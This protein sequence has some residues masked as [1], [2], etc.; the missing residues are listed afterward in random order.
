MEKLIIAVSSRA[1]FHIEDGNDIFVQQGQEA[2]DAY[3]RSK[4][5]TPLRPGAAFNLV[6]KLLKL[7]EVLV[8]MGRPALVDVVIL[9]RNS[10]DAG[11]RVMNSIAHYGLPIERAV[12]TQG[13][14]RFRYAKAFGAQLF[15]S[16]NPSDVRTAIENGM[17]A[18]TLVPYESDHGDDTEVRIAFDGD[19]VIFG[20]ESDAQYRA[21]G[22]AGWRDFE[23]ENAH[24][25]LSDGPFKRVLELMH[26]IQSAFEGGPCPVKI[27]LV[28]ARGMPAHKRVIR[29]LRHWGLRVDKAIFAGGRP[30]GPLL[31]AFGADMFFDDT[32]T[33]V[34]SAAECKVS[35]GHV[36]FGH[37][38]IVAEPA[39]SSQPLRAAA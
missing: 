17:A 21:V 18:A 14:D 31:V 11:M 10:P 13:D 12:F 8:S 22:L 7:N 1:L 25:V 20:S 35:A 34:E 2:F 24:T 28:T 6:R 27:A 30:K 26:A 5:D 3:M 37:G 23:E 29:T 38:G 36:P 33:N 4:E 15:L 32:R 39:A 16:A 19:S 9:S